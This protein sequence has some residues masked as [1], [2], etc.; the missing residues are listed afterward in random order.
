M[1]LKHTHEYTHAHNT[2]THAE[3]VWIWTRHYIYNS[4]YIIGIY[5]IYDVYRLVTHTH[6]HTHTSIYIYIYIYVY[7]YIYSS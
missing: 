4:I 7:I 5:N 2:Y 1:P 3:C 6:T